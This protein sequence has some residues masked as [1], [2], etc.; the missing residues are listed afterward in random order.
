LTLDADIRR[1]NSPF[2]QRRVSIRARSDTVFKKIFLLMLAV[3]LFIPL[4]ACRKKE[5]AIDIS[6]LIGD[7]TAFNFGEL[8]TFDTDYDGYID[9]LVY[10]LERQ[11]LAEDLFLDRSIQYTESED[12]FT[13]ELVLEF[14]NTGDESITYSHTEIIPKSFAESVD[15]LEFSA[16]PR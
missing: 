4:A 10:T 16:P 9:S 11:E 13:G 12:V 7:Q 5:E 15:D 1:L 8:E 2:D 3:L 6:A 14:E